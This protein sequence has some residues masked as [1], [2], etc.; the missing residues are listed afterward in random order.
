MNRYVFFLLSFS[1]SLIL[2]SPPLHVPLLPLLMRSSLCAPPTPPPHPHCPSSSHELS[3][4]PLLRSSSLLAPRGGEDEEAA[5][6]RNALRCR[7]HLTYHMI[8]QCI[9]KY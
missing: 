4:P 8:P 9:I 6:N 1:F 3:P 5:M 7:Y 2:L